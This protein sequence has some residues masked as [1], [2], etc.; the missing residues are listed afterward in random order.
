[1]RV[2]F[3][4]SKFDPL[5]L[6][7]GLAF[8]PMVEGVGRIRDPLMTVDAPRSRLVHSA[9]RGLTCTVSCRVVSSHAS[10][11]D[12]ALWEVVSY[13]PERYR[14]RSEMPSRRTFITSTPR[15]RV[16]SEVAAK[17]HRVGESCPIMMIDV[18]TCEVFAADKIGSLAS[19]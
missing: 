19:L 10:L 5:A 17:C 13:D 12:S 4:C 14:T 15:R 6:A 8:I 7:R 3:D 16:D 11:C 9:R 2:C 18:H 1:L